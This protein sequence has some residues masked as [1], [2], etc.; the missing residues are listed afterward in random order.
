MSDLKDELRA[1]L[2]A[3]DGKAVTILGEI[4]AEYRARSFY[5]ESLIA[6]AAAKDDM[7][8]DGATWLIKSALE[9]GMS[10]SEQQVGQYIGQFPKLSSWAASLHACQ[11]VQFMEIP[12][13]LAD[14]AVRW[15]SELLD[16]DRPFLRAWAMDALCRIAVQHDAFHDAA[17]EA[18]RHA[19]QDKAASVRARARKLRPML[20]EAN[21]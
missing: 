3:F 16:H 1:R 12:S 6:L 13:G 8:S 17:S 19:S 21:C 7:V 14:P 2:Q 4:E 10:L 20:D 18:V 9:K 11:S 5:I 15:T